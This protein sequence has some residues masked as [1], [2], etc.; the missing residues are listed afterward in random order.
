MIGLKRGAGQAM[1]TLIRQPEFRYPSF[2]FREFKKNSLAAHA[3][4]S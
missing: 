3:Q 4:I 2:R 1:E